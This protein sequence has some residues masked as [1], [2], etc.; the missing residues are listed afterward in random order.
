M[1]LEIEAHITR[2]FYKHIF[3]APSSARQE[4]TASSRPKIKRPQAVL[5]NMNAVTPGSIAY[6]AL[7]VSD[8]FDLKSSTLVDVFQVSALHQFIR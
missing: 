2:Q 8:A 5:N 4:L 7:M 6:A 1:I 3:M